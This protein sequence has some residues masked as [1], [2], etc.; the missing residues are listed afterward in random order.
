MGR[1]GQRRAQRGRAA[2]V[3]R[4][5]E[6]PGWKTRPVDDRLVI[7]GEKAGRIAQLANTHRHEIGLEE[8]SG[9]FG[10]KPPRP[11]GAGAH[12]FERRVYR[13]GIWR[14]AWGLRTNRP[15]AG[16][17]LRLKG[18]LA[19]VAGR[20]KSNRLIALM[21][22][23]GL[24]AER[25]RT[26]DWAA[27]RI[28]SRKSARMIVACP[29]VKI[30]PFD[31]FQ[32]GIGNSEPPRWWINHCGAFRR[33]RAGDGV[34]FR[35]RGRRVLARF[36]SLRRGKDCEGHRDEEQKTSQQ[37]KHRPGPILRPLSGAECYFAPYGHR[38]ARS[39]KIALAPRPRPCSQFSSPLLC[40]N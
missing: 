23:G 21:D 13:P 38:D 25:T 5:G 36:G 11:D 20:L 18:A 28:K 22:L 2:A 24:R 17:G 1:R 40:K 26:N 10:I 32:G 8:Q 29:A 16:V 27:T 34:D 4:H 3:Q 15:H 39:L 35:K 6:L 30:A 33:R 9:R 31:R 7:A 14:G 19:G 12:L 37:R